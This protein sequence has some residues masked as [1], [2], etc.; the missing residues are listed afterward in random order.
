MEIIFNVGIGEDDYSRDLLRDHLSNLQKVAIETK[1]EHGLENN[2]FVLACIE[3]N[4]RWFK[5]VQML[6]PGYEPA[7]THDGVERSELLSLSNEACE[8][9]AKGF[10]AYAETIQ[11]EP[12][13][14]MYK[15]LVF[16]DMSCAM[17]EIEAENVLRH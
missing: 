6:M 9:I 12:S 11:C 14:G 13:E 10:P 8:A 4:S 3:T 5:I 17:Y 7:P 15:V 2:E 1:L 16:S